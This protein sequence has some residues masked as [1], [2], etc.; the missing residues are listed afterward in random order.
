MCEYSLTMKRDGRTLD[1]ATLETIRKMA[2]QR[3]RGGG[4]PRALTAGQERRV[5]RWIDGKNPMRYDF[6]FGQAGT[7]AT[8]T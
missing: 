1:R 6:D 8:M 2:V 3:V 4:R 7:I 5:F